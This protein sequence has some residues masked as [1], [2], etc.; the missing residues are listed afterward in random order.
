MKLNTL[1]THDR[2]LFF[3]KQ[4]DEITKGCLDCIN[5]RPQEFRKYPFYIYAHKRELGI[6]D[7]IDRFD[8]DL[9]ESIVNP[10]YNRK[11]NLLIDVP[12]HRLIWMPRL[13]KPKFEPNSMLFKCYP[14]QDFLLKIYWILPQ[15]E[16]WEQFDKG[17]MTASKDV[18]ESIYNYRNNKDRMEQKDEDDLPDE[19]VNA[20]YNEISI[21]VRYNK[22]MKDLWLSK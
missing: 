19:K 20:I 7:R 3:Q 15:I 12:T 13:S 8:K 5:S 21:N 2:L 11:Y 10:L 16:L 18:S 4:S 1:E 9:Q 6:D 22:H 17:K 14:E